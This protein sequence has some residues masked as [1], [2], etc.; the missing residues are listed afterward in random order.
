MEITFA[1]VKLSSNNLE[2][3]IDATGDNL[4]PF[5]SRRLEQ[6]LFVSRMQF[7]SD[8]V[9]VCHAIKPRPALELVMIWVRR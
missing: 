1:I 4:H 5:R 6:T 9:L 8:E 7:T 2:I 3:Y